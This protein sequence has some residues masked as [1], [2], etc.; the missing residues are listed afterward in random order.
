MSLMNGMMIDESGFC[1]LRKAT[2]M[3]VRNW[4]VPVRV[5][6]SLIRELVNEVRIGE[7]G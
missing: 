1:R 2:V 5:R 7:G 4:W 6:C 3:G